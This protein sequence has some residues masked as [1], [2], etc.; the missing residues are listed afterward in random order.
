MSIYIIRCCD[1][2]KR[3]SRNSINPGK[4]LRGITDVLQSDNATGRADGIRDTGAPEGCHWR[5]AAL[6]IRPQL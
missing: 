6:L 2:F 4:Y 3:D 1:L 5:L